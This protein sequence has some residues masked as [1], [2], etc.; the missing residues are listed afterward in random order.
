MKKR[1]FSL[2]MAIC[3]ALTILPMTA[4]GADGGTYVVYGDDSLCGTYYNPGDQSNIM[5]QS[6]AVYT[7]TY[8][9]VA[10][11]DYEM[12]V[13]KVTNFDYPYSDGFEGYGAPHGGNFH[14]TVTAPC[15][16]TVTFDPATKEITVSG[17]YIAPEP[18]FEVGTVYAV[19]EG[20]GTWLNGATWN[21][22]EPANQM[23]EVET[24]VFEIVFSGVNAGTYEFKFAHNGEWYENWGPQEGLLPVESGK[25]Y[26]AVFCGIG[27]FELTVPADDSRVTLRLDLTDLGNPTVIVTIHT[28]IWDPQWSTDDTHHWRECQS[29]GCLITDN[30]QKDGYGAHSYE[31]FALPEFLVSNATCTS[32][33]VYY[34]SCICGRLSTETFTDD[35]TDP[36]GHYGTDD[37]ILS[38]GNGSHS[39]VWT[40]CGKPVS[41]NIACTPVDADDTCLTAETCICG[42]VIQAAATEHDFSGDLLS[43]AEGH[44]HKCKNCSVTDTKEAHSATEDGNCTTEEKCACGTVVIEA[45]DD[46]D[47]DHACDTHCNNPGCKYTRTTY[48]EPL[49]DDGDCKTPVRCAICQEITTEAK[50]DHS[51]DNT[52]DTTCNNKDC[53]HTRTI[54]HTPNEDDGDCET[55]IHC[56][57][58]DAITTPAKSHSYTNACDT[59]CN[60]DGCTHTRVTYHG[61][62]PDDGNCTTP[63]RC[64]ICQEITTEAKE[65]HSFDNTCDTTCNNK[66]CKHTRTITHTPNEDDGDCETAI[67]CKICDAITTP[68]KIHSYTNACDT[69]CNNDGCT[70]TRTTEHRP[71][72]DDGDCT[73]DILC[74]ICDG[75]TTKGNESHTGGT[76]TCKAKA[77]CT[78]CG[79]AYGNT[80]AHTPEAD[81]GDCTTDILCSVCDSVT[82]KGNESHTGGTATCTAKAKCEICEAEYGE[83]G[84]HGET[85]IK[86]AKQASCTAEGYTGDI[87]CK[88][89]GEK[90][91]SGRTVAKTAH[92]YK[93]GKCAVCKQADPNYNPDIPQTGDPTLL[94]L[95]LALLVASACGGLAVLA[96]N[97]KKAS[98]R[99]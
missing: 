34:R 7:K 51:F 18:Q 44:W 66:D 61:P 98:Y 57:I 3:M 58:C 20:S 71:E 48:H 13:G 74:S 16:V 36:E 47:F 26:A 11:G 93:A 56:K 52:C 96:V 69:T 37:C 1:I 35:H 87:F 15:D 65:D 30:A 90:L 8:T 46:H 42:Y 38:N 84:A 80:L 63:I 40:C 82:T 76:A 60:N 9:N 85:E 95:W 88:A 79:T 31:E 75:V 50:E 27:N 4:H 97:R 91:E 17:L 49:P 14:F 6:G 5:T 64:A 81:D 54:T 94:G 89:C 39:I 22:G 73:T 33:S 24:G 62:L 25:A 99:K 45:K 10:A 78:V 68:A 43:N 21:P 2:L 23:T 86:D 59:T 53:K 28:H 92:S 41:E 19:G 29:E 67:H 72:E 55:A 77:E 70:F 12:K 32:G 83:L